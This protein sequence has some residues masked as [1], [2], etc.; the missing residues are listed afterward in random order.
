MAILKIFSNVTFEAVDKMYLVCSS[1]CC[2]FI[3]G[4][5]CLSDQQVSLWGHRKPGTH[6]HL[7]SHRRTGDSLGTAEVPPHEK[8]DFFYSTKMTRRFLD[9]FKK[10]VEFLLSLVSPWQPVTTT[11]HP[12]SVSTSVLKRADS[13]FQTSHSLHAYENNFT[14]VKTGVP[15]IN[16]VRQ[17]S[18]SKTLLLIK[19]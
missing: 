2:F 4:I 11:M 10:T 17:K 14:S 8:C 13:A 19:H 15:R 7:T 3:N 12:D 16:A 1:V 9:A 18:F 6:G 5:P